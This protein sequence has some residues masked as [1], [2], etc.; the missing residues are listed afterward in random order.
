MR[1]RIPDVIEATVI[2][3]FLR[4]S[5][6][7]DFAHDLRL[8]LQSKGRL[9]QPQHIV[10]FTA[11]PEVQ[12]KLK[13]KKPVSQATAKRWMGRLGYLWRRTFHGQYI[14]GH[15]REDVVAYRQA[16]VARWKE[17]ERRFHTF[18]NDGN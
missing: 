9:A 10:E 17:Y 5:E 16:F 1:N 3:D 14:D 8:Y 12:E 2:D 4:G 7:P 15:E 13:L 11:L 6:D 18:D